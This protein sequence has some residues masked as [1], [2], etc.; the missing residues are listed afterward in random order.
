MAVSCF[1]R[2]GSWCAL[3]LHVAALLLECQL[4]VSLTACRPAV[5]LVPLLSLIHSPT[6][7]LRS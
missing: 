5:A 2:C 4:A 1:Y 7:C 3:M 6:L